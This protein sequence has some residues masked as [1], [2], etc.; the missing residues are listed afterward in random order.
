MSE[1]SP[2]V[3]ELQRARRTVLLSAS[4]WTQLPDTTCDRQAWAEYRQ[5][6][7]DLPADPN[8]PDV[9]FPEPPGG[10]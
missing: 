5:Q 2:T 1:I 10:V 6:L 9:E 4:D 7:R 3:E 8:W